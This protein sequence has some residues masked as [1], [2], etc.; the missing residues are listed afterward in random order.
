MMANLITKV[1]RKGAAGKGD[2]WYSSSHKSHPTNHVTSR[3][4]VTTNN[5]QQDTK[6]S[7]FM[8][9][10]GSKENPD[11]QSSSGSE[12]HLAL[13][14]STRSGITKTVETTIVRHDLDSDSQV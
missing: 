6:T 10:F 8:S 9:K 11:R 7:T 14:P 1:V 3:V 5:H 4:V 13:Y 12:V 2:E